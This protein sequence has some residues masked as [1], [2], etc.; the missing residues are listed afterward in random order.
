MFSVVEGYGEVQENN[1][2]Q[3]LGAFSFLTDIIA[4]SVSVECNSLFSL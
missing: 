3:L 2:R 1:E 4:F